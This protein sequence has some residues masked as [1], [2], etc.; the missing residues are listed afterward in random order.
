MKLYLVYAMRGVTWKEQGIV[1]AC[2]VFDN[3]EDAEKF[4][5]GAL[6]VEIVYDDKTV[7]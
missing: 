7:H 6:V 4:A 2:P 1:G 5:K 3:K